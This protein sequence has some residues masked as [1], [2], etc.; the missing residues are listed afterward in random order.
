MYLDT[1]VNEVEFLKT[2]FN[3]YGENQDMSIRPSIFI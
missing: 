3:T 2:D 1:E